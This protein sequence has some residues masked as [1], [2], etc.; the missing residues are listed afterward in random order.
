[1]TTGRVTPGRGPG[2]DLSQPVELRPPTPAGNREAIPDTEQPATAETLPTGAGRNQRASSGP[3]PGLFERL[4]GHRASI[5]L[6]LGLLTAV[7]VVH[8]TG[9]ARAPQRIDDEGTYVA[10]AWAVQQWHTLG[11]YTYW[12]DH[13]PFGWLLLAAWTSLTGAFDRT[14]TAIAAG[15]EFMLAVQLVSAALLYGVA[16]RLGLRRAA[17]AGPCWPSASPRSPW[18]CTGPSTSTTSPRH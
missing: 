10:Q 16:R 17:A 2:T 4:W 6:L 3:Q 7:A 1:V 14:A 12:Y 18:A 5:A 15:R 8:T 9:M 13:P 11:H